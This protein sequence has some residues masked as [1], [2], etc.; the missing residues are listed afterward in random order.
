MD[1]VF[2]VG[3]IVV[4]T[5][6]IGTKEKVNFRGIVD[7]RAVIVTSRGIQVCVPVK[8]IAKVAQQEQGKI[9]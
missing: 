4:W 3:E 6:A 9:D 8:N 5:T 1:T 7:D 2:N